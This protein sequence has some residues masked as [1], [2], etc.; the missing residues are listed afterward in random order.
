MAEIATFRKNK[1]ELADYDYSHD[2][3]NRVLMAQFSPLEVEVLEEILYSSL[4][5][6]LSLLKQ[7]LDLEMEDLTSILE[8]LSQTKL[9]TISSDHVVVDKEMR[10]Y[11]EAQIL[12]FEED[13]HPGMEYLQL[14]LKKVPI[15]AL[16]NWY[17]ISRTSNNIFE[18]IVEKYLLTPQIFQRYFLD[19][20]FADPLLNQIVEALYQSNELEIDAAAILE[21]YDLTQEQ[22]EEHM[23]TL[24]Y[25]LVAC[26]KYVK[27]GRH[28]KEVVTPFQEWKEYLE[29]I[30]RRAPEPL[31]D[32][33]NVE[34]IKTSDFSMVE[35]MTAILEISLEEPITDRAKA[36]EL[37][38]KKCPEFEIEDFDFLVE[39]L[40]DLNLAVLEGEKVLCTS[41]SVEFLKKKNLDRAIYL[42]RHPLNSLEHE[43]V[44]EELCTQ[45]TVREAE[46]SIL[47]CLYAGWVDLEEFIKGICIPLHESQLISLRRVGRTWKYQFPEYNEEELKFFKAI[48]QQWLFEVGITTLGTYQGRECFRINH[49]GQELFGD[50]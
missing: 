28:Y 47:P 14:L 29:R 45:R 1:I 21:N 41:D 15:H 23:L 12:K 22:F 9:F 49:F 43:D 8:K 17:S 34:P 6:P 35:E 26:I 36:A 31:A 18:S 24:E 10:K 38:L 48:I 19:L 2:I 44:P 5:I 46:K 30:K 11:Y 13:F 3:Q 27:E 20:Q 4:R 33:E 16:P 25:S 7:N 39:K 42:Y 37:V 40:S 50:E 32:Q